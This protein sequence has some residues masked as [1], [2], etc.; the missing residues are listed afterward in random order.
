MT[1]QSLTRILIF[2]TIL[3]LSLVSIVFRDVD[4]V[5]DIVNYI[6]AYPQ[7]CNFEVGYCFFSNTFYQLGYEY[8]SF[9][10]FYFFLSFAVLIFSLKSVAKYAGVDF[11]VL[12]LLYFF[13]LFYLHQITQ[14]RIGMALSFAYLA[15]VCWKKSE[16]KFSLFYLL[17]SLSFHIST[18][19]ICIAFFV[20]NNCDKKTRIIFYGMLPYAFVASSYFSLFDLST[21][22]KFLAVYIK[23]MEIY[24]VLN[25]GNLNFIS[26]KFLLMLGYIT[27]F[28]VYNLFYSVESRA[29]M[30][31]KVITIALCLFIFLSPQISLAFRV[32]EIFELLFLVLMIIG[33]DKKF[34]RTFRQCSFFVIVLY[35]LLSLRAVFFLDSPLFNVGNVNIY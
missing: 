9:S 23:K 35:S 29:V 15:Y 4:V 7:N 5:F 26:G 11:F 13:Y 10:I 1:V 27:L 22:I 16:K 19:L 31:G 3:Y 6:E 30:F 25:G 8:W 32:F 14:V 17:L 21:L 34:K 2:I 12:F 28:W 20:N 33:I 24:S 18:V